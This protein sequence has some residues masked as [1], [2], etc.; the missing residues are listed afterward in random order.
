MP[1]PDVLLEEEEEGERPD[2]LYSGLNLTLR[3]GLTGDPKLKGHWQWMRRGVGKDEFSTVPSSTISS[4]SSHSVIH[5][6]ETRSGSVTYQCVYNIEGVNSIMANDRIN[7]SISSERSE[8]NYQSIY[9]LSV[10][11]PVSEVVVKSVNSSAINV[12]WGE[13]EGNSGPIS[14]YI[15]WVRSLTDPADIHTVGVPISHPRSVVISQLSKPLQ[16][17][18]VLL[19][20]HRPIP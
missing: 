4:N 6:E 15:V 20:F 8:Q 7:L 17:T 18:H 10:S 11:P 16:S 13:P 5:Y 3:C 14:H 12:S 9:I 2:I 19:Q 1:T